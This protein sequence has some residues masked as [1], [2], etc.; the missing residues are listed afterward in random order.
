MNIVRAIQNKG[1]NKMD[2]KKVASEILV[3]SD[4]RKMWSVMQ[5]C[6]TRLVLQ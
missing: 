6:M 5:T 1:L 2:A 3:R 4:R